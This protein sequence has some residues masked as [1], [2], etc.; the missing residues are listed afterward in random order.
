MGGTSLSV[1]SKVIQNA[2]SRAYPNPLPSN[3]VLTQTADGQAAVD[4][5][6][7]VT[8]T[9]QPKS[10]MVWGGPGVS[11]PGWKWSSGEWN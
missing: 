7:S 11:S 6:D 5:G 3:Q 2:L 4:V 10:A 1:L 8:T 9:L